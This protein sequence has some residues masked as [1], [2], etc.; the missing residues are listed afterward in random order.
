[1]SCDSLTM[2]PGVSRLVLIRHGEP[3]GWVRGRCY[4]DLDPG[5][6]STGREQVQRARRWLQGQP[7]AAVYSSPRRRALESADVLTGS[8]HILEDD[9]LREI[10][11]GEFEGLT[12]DEIADRFPDTYDAWMRRPTAMSFPGGESFTAM[13]RRVREALTHLRRA[14]AGQVIA[15]VSHGGVN[16][17]ALADALEMPLYRLFRLHQ[18]YGC[19]NV[20][21]YIREEPI[22]R[23]VNGRCRS[24]C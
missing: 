3:E 12:Y 17:I 20:I 7:V 11:F 21:D 6:S 23:L 9:R 19:V 5:L 22:V 10:S 8:G 4:G 14:H 15:L 16:R 24:Q 13:T 1:M 18:D 2:T